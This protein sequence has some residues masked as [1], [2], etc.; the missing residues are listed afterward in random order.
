MPA[1]S[2]RLLEIAD[3]QQLFLFLVQNTLFKGS[4]S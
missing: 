2:D 3:S 1:V 4:V